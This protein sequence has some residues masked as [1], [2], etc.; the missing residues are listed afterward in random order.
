MSIPQVLEAALGMALTYYLLG[1]IV[2]WI[3]QFVMDTFETRGK[4]LEGYLRRIVGNKSL[5]QLVSM[6][7]IR[8]LAPVRYQGWLG[9][10]TRKV[11]VVEKKV[12][13]IPATNLVD[14]FFD[15]IQINPAA[16]G[17]ELV[18]TVNKLPPSEGKT[19]LLRL[20]NS[21]VTHSADLRAKMGLWFDGLMDQSSAL[22]KALARRYIFLFA[23]LITLVFGV[24]SLDLFRQLWASPDMR[25]IAAVKAQA[26]VQQNGYAA[27]TGPLLADLDELTIRV[28]WSST[29]KNMPPGELNLDFARFWLLKI[30]GLLITAIAVSQGSSFWYDVLHKV[31]EA[32]SQGT[33]SGRSSEDSAPTPI[34][35]D[36][37]AGLY[38]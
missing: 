2:S 8:S 29:L 6:P 17:E 12:E 16:N 34:G 20:I 7:Q 37:G 36:T 26:Y 4:M 18:S 23:L 22:F 38:R 14:A 9:F 15:L 10:L 35:P 24:D 19:E 11:T 1:L 31:T 32:K 3:S 33:S 13:K 30:I 21:G 25:A 5:G 27:D 28:G